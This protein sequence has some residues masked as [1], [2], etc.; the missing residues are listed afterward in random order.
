MH[1]FVR[2]K[3]PQ[4]RVS[5]PS[6]PYLLKPL[7]VLPGH[8]MAPRYLLGCACVLNPLIVLPELNMDHYLATD[9]SKA[10]WL[11]ALNRHKP[12]LVSELTDI[13][14][15]AHLAPALVHGFT[16]HGSAVALLG[17]AN[18]YFQRLVMNGHRVPVHATIKLLLARLAC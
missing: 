10:S 12:L 7:S 3:Y 1:I 15:L 16:S 13:F 2:F 18:G 6:I 17:D 5:C 8:F 11:C 4:L 14:F 9:P